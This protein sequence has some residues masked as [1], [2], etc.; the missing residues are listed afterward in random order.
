MKKISSTEA[1]W[2]GTQLPNAAH[3]CLEDPDQVEK[4][5]RVTILNE[6]T[7]NLMSP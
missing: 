5:G 1:K 4:V 7:Y 3:M 2:D 6:V